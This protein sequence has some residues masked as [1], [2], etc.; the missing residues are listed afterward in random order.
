MIDRY[1]TKDYIDRW[2]KEL[3]D[4]HPHIPCLYAVNKIDTTVEVTKKNHFPL[5][6]NT[7]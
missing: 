4:I 6:E 2:Y 5:Q 7:I 3:H 1:N